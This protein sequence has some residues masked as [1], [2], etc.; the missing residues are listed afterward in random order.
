MYEVDVTCGPHDHHY[1]RIQQSTILG[2]FNITPAWQASHNWIQIV[3]CLVKNAIW[4][5]MSWY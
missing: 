1:S 4:L 2:T 5:E 3:P